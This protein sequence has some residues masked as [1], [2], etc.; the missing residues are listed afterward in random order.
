MSDY[1]RN[2]RARVG[3]TVLSVPSVTGLVF[4]D[5][6]S[7]L[8]VRHSNGGIW[9]APGGAIEPDEVPQEAVVREVFEET[10]L[11]VEPTRLVGVYGG[12]DFRVTYE[13]G[14]QTSY[15]MVVF[16]CRRLGGEHRADQDEILDAR[17]FSA[18][19]LAGLDLGR[20]ARRILPGLM[21]PAARAAA[22]QYSR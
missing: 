11:R 13:N 2:L 1:M 5:A 8:L 6:G 15:T 10:G 20:W 7:I 19:E 17:W 3:N 14:D 16:E 9:V 18:G 4:D 12:P 21:D 22:S